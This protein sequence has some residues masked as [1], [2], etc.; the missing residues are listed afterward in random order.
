MDCIRVGSGQIEI[1]LDDVTVVFTHNDKDG[2]HKAA[3]QAFKGEDLY[4]NFKLG[5]FEKLASGCYDYDRILCP[6]EL[7]QLLVK[8]QTAQTN[9]VTMGKKKKVKA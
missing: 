3:V 8:V 7:I 5:M 9:T 1:E 2:S 6:K 4:Y